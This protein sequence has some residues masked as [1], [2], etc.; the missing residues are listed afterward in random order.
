VLCL[1]SGGGQQG[2]VLAAAGADVTVLDNSPRQLAQ[3]ESVA[4]R[5]GLGIATVLGDMADL[6]MFS[7]GS[8]D[9][10]VHPCSNSF[11]PNL[12][13]VWSEAYRVLRPNCSLLSGFSNGVIYLFDDEAM[14]QG[15]LKIAHSL[16]YSDLEGLSEQKLAQRVADGMPL[17][18]GHTLADQIGGQLEAGFLLSAFYEDSMPGE[19][20][21]ER[22]STYIATMAVKTSRE[23]PG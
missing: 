17:E 2:P 3:D 6:S 21:A 8:F 5:D 10:I 13:P 19:L 11:I 1:A 23:G 18:F 14:D 7:D 22:I 15:I 9:L 4:K 20:L 12:R 16:P